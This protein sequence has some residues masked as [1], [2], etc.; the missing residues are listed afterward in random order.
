M[1]YVDYPEKFEVPI[2]AD[3]RF[4]TALDVA[5][6]TK[7]RSFKSSM[8]SSS[9]TDKF[10]SLGKSLRKLGSKKKKVKISHEDDGEAEKD[11]LE[12]KRNMESKSNIMLAGLILESISSFGIMNAS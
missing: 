8:P 5:L 9:V 7:N 3:L 10:K 4:N 12:E 6:K 11:I 2:L 1:A